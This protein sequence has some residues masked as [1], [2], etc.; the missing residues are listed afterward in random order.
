M[1]DVARQLS[2][3]R[4]RR[5]ALFVTLVASF[6]IPFSG[7][8]LNLAIPVIGLELDLPALTLNWIVTAYI[9]ASAVA[10]LPMG[11]LADLTGRRRLFLAGLLGFGA[12]SVAC[13]L[14]GSGPAIVAARLLQGL[15]GAMIFGTATAILISAYPASERGRVLGWNVAAVYSGLSLGP[16]LGGILT[17][18]VGWRSIF[19]LAAGLAGVAAALVAARLRRELPVAGAGRFDL[20]GAVA[21]G[22]G[23]AGLMIGLSSVR[24]SSYGLWLA[25]AGALLISVCVWRQARV[26]HPLLELRLFRSPV[27]LRSNAAALIHYAATFASSYLVSLYLQVVRGIGPRD[28]GLVLLIQPVLMALLSPLSGRLSDRVEPRVLA[29]S[30]MAL[31]CVGLVLFTQ[32]GLDTPIGLLIL[33][34][35]FLG[36]G[37]ALFSSPNTNAVMSSVAGSDYGVASATLGTMRLLGQGT[38]MVLVSVVFGFVIGNTQLSPDNAGPLLR[39]ARLSFQLLAVLCA[40]GIAP[41]LARGQLRPGRSS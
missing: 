33:N 3:A 29:S 21:Y 10:L 34:L 5:Y 24:A 12:A 13:A 35:A 8:A 27:F 11:K 17:E 14:A 20:A 15:A 38:S 6:I 36:V 1:P 39:A 32:L 30:G 25:A 7:S 31:T 16:V 37:F 22:L 28:A 2:E 18:Q 9:V 23:I 41:S 4:E 19:W 26:R 40:I